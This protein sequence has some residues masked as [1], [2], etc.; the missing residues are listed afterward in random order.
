[1]LF[2]LKIINVEK[3]ITHLLYNF[4]NIVALLQK[5]RPFKFYTIFIWI[6]LKNN[7][8]NYTINNLNES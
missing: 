6:Y 5:M 1:M 4:A 2:W 3:G 7:N 8:I